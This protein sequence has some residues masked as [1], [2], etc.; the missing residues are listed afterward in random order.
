[1]ST[2][3]VAVSESVSHTE[4]FGKTGLID[5]LIREPRIAASHDEPHLSGLAREKTVAVGQRLSAY[6]HIHYM[7]VYI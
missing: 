6:I 3:E 1:M 2:N 7:Y 5:V 4:E